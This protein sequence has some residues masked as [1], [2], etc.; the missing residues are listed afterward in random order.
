MSFPVEQVANYGLAGL[1]IILFYLFAR[2]TV[3]KAL[4]SVA[5]SLDNNTEAL[6]QIRVVIE[7]CKGPT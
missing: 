7:K 2:D 3:K 6:N 5:V 1:A 4:E